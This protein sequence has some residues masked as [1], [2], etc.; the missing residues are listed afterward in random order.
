[1]TV[2]WLREAVGLEGKRVLLRIDANVPLLGGEI[3]DDFRLKKVLP[4]IE[5]LRSKGARVVIISHLESGDGAASLRP[6][7]DY[8]GRFFPITFD[9]IREYRESSGEEMVLLENLRANPGEAANDPLFSDILAALGDI[10]VN[11]AF[12]VSHRNHASIVGVPSRLPSYG[13]LLLESEVRNL[14]KAFNPPH[15]FVFIIGGL[16]FQTKVPL[17]QKIAKTADRIFVCGALA[18]SFWKAKGLEVGDSAV[19]SDLNGIKEF[20]SNPVISLPEDVIVTRGGKE[21][22]TSPETVQKGDVIVDAGPRALERIKKEISGAKL[23]LWNGPLG[24]FEEGFHA[25]TN[26]LARAIA[27]LPPDAIS[28]VGGGDT[29]ASIE[30][31]HVLEKFGFVSTGGGAM[32]DFLANETLPGLEALKKSPRSF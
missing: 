31:A 15:P 30:E 26:A 28:L 23:V 18:N 22:T 14:S 24:K 10:Y 11:D 5:F 12:A 13:G 1:M 17:V 21:V 16:K 20:A 9:G 8:F 29:I 27:D 4:T 25:G 7:A 19:D 6:V 32:L 3:T 2:R